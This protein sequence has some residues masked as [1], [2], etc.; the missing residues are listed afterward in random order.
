M[1][2]NTKEFRISLTWS[3]LTPKNIFNKVIL[4]ENT[5][6]FNMKNN[7]SLEYKLDSIDKLNFNQIIFD[8]GSKIRFH[9][10]FRAY[11]LYENILDKWSRKF[12]EKAEQNIRRQIK[13][14][15][16]A[17]I[18]LIFMISLSV[19]LILLDYYV[20]KSSGKKPMVIPLVICALAIN[21]L[22]LFNH[23]SYKKKM[24]KYIN[25]GFDNTI[26]GI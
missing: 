9:R 7:H 18:G 8:D 17:S 10:A 20:F 26:L 15:A 4:S 21:F 13:G 5:L 22:T 16:R 1:N 25:S 3:R 11:K 2:N 19:S 6:K 24:Q 14:S 12:P 23:G